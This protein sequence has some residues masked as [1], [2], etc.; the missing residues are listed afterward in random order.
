[1][2]LVFPEY[3]DIDLFIINNLQHAMR[4]DETGFTR[5]MTFYVENHRG[6]SS[7]FDDISYSKGEFLIFDTKFNKNSNFLYDKD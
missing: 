1:M 3:R 5:P 7:L 2:S 4:V 6:I